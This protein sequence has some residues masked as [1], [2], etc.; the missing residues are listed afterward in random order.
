MTIA[1]VFPL[2]STHHLSPTTQQ[3]AVVFLLREQALFPSL[4][5][6][7]WYTRERAG[8]ACIAN[9]KKYFVD[10]IILPNTEEPSLESTACLLLLLAP[11]NN[12]TQ[13]RNKNSKQQKTDHSLSS[14]HR[15]CCPLEDMVG[16]ILIL[17]LS[18][19]TPKASKACMCVGVGN[20]RVCVKKLCSTTPARQKRSGKKWHARA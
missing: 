13:Q 17:P 12:K 11:G 16:E 6:V 10:V 9:E 2:S 1:S 18:E 7:A 19:S 15:A 5:G 14:T 8:H 3:R 20:K 4:R